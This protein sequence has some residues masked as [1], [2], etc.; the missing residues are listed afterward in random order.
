MSL[1]SESF[2]IE[3]ESLKVNKSHERRNTCVNIVES[4]KEWIA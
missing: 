1:T 4:M 2:I 3:L